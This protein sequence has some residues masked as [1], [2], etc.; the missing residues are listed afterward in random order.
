MSIDAI[1]LASQILLTILSLASIYLIASQ[2]RYVR[3]WAGI[4]GTASEPF[5]MITFYING[6]WVMMLLT[7]VYTVAWINVIRSNA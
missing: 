5:W 7:L 1:D 4:L 2:E 6:Q 3:W